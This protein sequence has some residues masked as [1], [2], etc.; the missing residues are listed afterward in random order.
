MKLNNRLVLQNEVSQVLTTNVWLEMVSVCRFI[1]GMKSEKLRLNLAII[2]SSV[3]SFGNFV[4]SYLYI[5]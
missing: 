5:Q 1:I 2:M 3:Q 4:H